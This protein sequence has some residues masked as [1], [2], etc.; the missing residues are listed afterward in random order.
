MA[1]AV[2]RAAIQEQ[3]TQRLAQANA[4]AGKERRCLEDHVAVLLVS[5]TDLPNV[6]CGLIG[7]YH[8]PS[9]GVARL[10]IA[11][12]HFTFGNETTLPAETR[13][14]EVIDLLD[15]EGLVGAIN[16]VE[17]KWM[18]WVIFLNEEGGRWGRL[19]DLVELGVSSLRDILD[20]HSA[21]FITNREDTYREPFQK[22]PF[23]HP[24]CSSLFPSPCRGEDY[25]VE[26]EEVLMYDNPQAHGRMHVR[27]TG[28]TTI[29]GDTMHM[30]I[31]IIA[32]TGNPW[33][34][35]QRIQPMHRDALQPGLQ[36]GVT[37][38]DAGVI[39]LTLSGLARIVDSHHPDLRPTTP[40]T[41]PP[42]MAR[43]K[44]STKK[45]R[46]SSSSSSGDSPAKQT[47][48]AKAKE[49]KESKE[50]PGGEETKGDET[51]EE[52]DMPDPELTDDA[53]VRVLTHII[54]INE[55]V[56]ILY[57]ILCNNIL[58]CMDNYNNNPY[59]IAYYVIISYVVWIITII[60]HTLLQ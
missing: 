27:T 13:I 52:E 41:T 55:Y 54:A 10:S 12:K 59:F 37:V 30:S 9:V 31:H 48:S 24:Y 53:E 57:C 3:A 60:I 1:L 21:F 42:T 58:C 5:A 56:S 8:N 4:R 16:A 51:P 19:R 35:Q 34:P 17:P 15:S 45:S 50:T 25:E 7:E 2:R 28:R 22:N 43:T 29:D 39:D 18:Y 38:D 47:R 40:P 23:A 33:P 46:S 20:H 26:S 11:G 6:I 49:S 14:S 32:A 44:R 36:P